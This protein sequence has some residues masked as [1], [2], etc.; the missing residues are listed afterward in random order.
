MYVIQRFALNQYTVDKLHDM[1]PEFGYNGFGEFIF[2]RTYS[3]WNGE[4][5]ENW[6]DC[7]VRVITGIASIRKDWYIKNYINWDEKFWQGY[8]SRMAESMFKM[9]W[10][11]PGRGLWACGTDFVY[12]RGSM[13]LYNCAFENIG[14]KMESDIGWMMDSLMLGV[15]VGFTPIRKEMVFKVPSHARYDLVIEDSR[16]GWVDSEYRLIQSIRRGTPRPRM[17]YDK[18]RG[19]GLPIRGFGGISSGPDPL[20]ELHEKTEELMEQYAEDSYYDSVMLKTDLAN[21]T[22]CCVVA[23]NVRRSAELGS[24]S[25]NDPVFLNLKNYEDP[26]YSYRVDWGYMSNNSV[27]LSEDSDFEMLD[28]IAER[29]IKRGEPGYHNLQ[30]FPHGRIGKKDRVKR[31]R[32][33]G[34][35][36]CFVETTFVALADGRG[37][38]K[39]KDLEGTDADVYTIDEHDEVVIRQARNFRKTGYDQKILK[40]TFDNGDEIRVTENHKFMMRDRSFKEAKDLRFNDQLTRFNRY[41]P[42]QIKESYFDQYI[43]IGYSGKAK[44]EHKLIGERKFGTV[45]DNENIHHIDGNKLNNNSDNLELK[46]QITHL[47]EHSYGDSNPKWSGYSNDDVIALGVSF[48]KKLGRRFFVNEWRDHGF[49]ALQFKG[50]RTEYFNSFYAFSYYCAEMAEVLNNPIDTRTLRFYEKLN[51]Q[52]Y[53]CE[54]VGDK[55]YVTKTCKNCQSTFSI[56][57]SEREQA[58][59]SLSCGISYSRRKDEYNIVREQQC[60]RNEDMQQRQADIFTR[61]KNQLGRYPTQEEWRYECRDENV[62]QRVNENGPYFQS[63]TGLHTYARTHN[64]RVLSVVEDGYEDVYNATVDDYHLLILGGWRHETPFGRIVE[65]GVISPQCGEIILQNRETCNIAETLPTR[66][67]NEKIWQQGCE[68]ATVYTSTVSLLP[69]HQPSTNRVVARNRRIGVGIVDYTGWKHICGVNKTTKWMREGYTR[70][71]KTNRW[72]NGEAGVPYAIRHTCVKPGGTVPKV[73]G[74]TP[75]V[76]HPTFKYTLRRIVVAKN[77]QV[78]QLL[79]EAN[80]P[81]EDCVTD[82][83]SYVFSWPIIQ[84]PS[85][86]AEEISLW[87]QAMNLVLLQREWADNAVS[88]TLYFRPKWVLQKILTDEI[89]LKNHIAETISE[90]EEFY[91]ITARMLA[92]EEEFI[93]GEC[94]ISIDYDD[95][96]DELVT[97]KVYRYDP[98]HEEA[99]IEAVLSAIAPLTKTVSLLPHTPEGVYA[100]MPES[101]LTEEQYERL[102]NQIRPIDWSKLKNSFGV[103]ERYCSGPQCEL[104]LPEALNGKISTDVPNRQSIA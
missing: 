33:K 78:A 90:E 99:S 84:G 29:V 10:L 61:L 12:E 26:R 35:N 40:I 3:R 79:I 89:G 20:R 15:G 7:V 34:C 25:V 49:F 72:T 48:A 97:A 46:D 11:P 24:Q 63:W 103:D 36:P 68:Y 28:K 65:S 45:D 98:A 32:G 86:P 21:I 23:G 22:G 16:E 87:E 4:R 81:Y 94:K 64:H 104:P 96:T 101:R 13:A 55:V 37:F 14:S 41:I 60:S 58:C 54:I 82:R 102:R 44:A 17:I 75:G 69:T 51:E 2:Y 9:E 56:K 93:V 74:R 50:Y 31:D 70:V 95:D 92:G 100:Q 47:S 1:E 52:G 27:Q 18:I 38:V 91:E 19:P 66:C 59:C 67:D 39:V 76:G 71:R 80:V 85:A 42:N 83:Y 8:F 88:N 57:A 5:Q 77:S 62:T 53:D 6:A 30:N 73:A 43:S